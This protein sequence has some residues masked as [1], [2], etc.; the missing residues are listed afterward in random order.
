MR[1]TGDSLSEILD[2]ANDAASLVTEIAMAAA[3]QARGLAEVN[4]G[5]SQLDTVTQQNSAMAAESSVA[6]KSLLGQ[7]EDLIRALSGFPHRA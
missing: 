7:S 4:T 1:R 6:A 3:D 2:R 5:V